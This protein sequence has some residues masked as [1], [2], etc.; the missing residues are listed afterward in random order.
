[1]KLAALILTIAFILAA[2]TIAQAST[3]QVGSTGPEVITLQK[4]LNFEGVSVGTAD[5]IFGLRTKQGV[6]M[7]QTDNGLT[8]NG[9]VGPITTRAI[10]TDSIITEAKSHIGLHYVWGGT[11]PVTGFDCSGFVQYV[12]K[13][14]GITLPRISRDQ[15]SRGIAV[16]FANLQPGDLVFFSFLNNRTVSHVGIYLGNGQFIGA[17]NAGIRVVTITQYWIS[18]FVTA[19]RVY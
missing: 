17:E 11:S 13:Q 9:I 5:G 7:F 15:A 16:T 19:R 3:M 18:R 4:D 10:K 6:I 8:P 14:N 12:F 2:P 1:M